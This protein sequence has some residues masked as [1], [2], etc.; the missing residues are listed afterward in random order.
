M[1]PTTLTLDHIRGD[2]EVFTITLTDGGVP[3]D[4]SVFTEATFRVDSR[5][6]GLTSPL[7]EKTLTGGGIVFTDA[8]NGILTVTLV[9]ADT[10]GIAMT[11]ETEAFQ[12]NLRLEDGTGAVQ[13]PVCG[14]FNL[15]YCGD[16][17]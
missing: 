4:L 9:P 15:R 2:T 5:F 12:W 6:P 7:L 10:S 13:S 17:P 3:I 1:I 8:V 14:P 11:R 16:A